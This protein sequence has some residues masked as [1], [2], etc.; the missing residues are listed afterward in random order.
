MNKYQFGFIKKKT[1]DDVK[2]IHPDREVEPIS[3]LIGRTDFFE[4]DIIIVPLS[5]VPQDLEQAVESSVGEEKTVRE[6]Q[7]AN[8]TVSTIVL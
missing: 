8:K 6:E 4:H 3:N 5:Q 1:F 7:E 2:L